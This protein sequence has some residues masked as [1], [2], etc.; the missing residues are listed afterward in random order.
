MIR[1]Y[2]SA[3][4]S[5][6][7]RIWLE[8]NIETHDF[9]PE[10]YWT[11]NYEPVKDMLPQAEIYVYEA[12]GSGQAEGFIGLTGSYIAGLFV[13]AGAQSK[14]IGTKLLEHAMQRRESLTLSVYRKNTRAI[15]FY[16]RHGFVI[17]SESIDSDT[18]EDEYTMV[19]NRQ[20]E[21][22]D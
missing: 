17:R 12:D 10:E 18:G 3:D 13:S 19:W 11:D 2:A 8:T 20:K 6:I 15:D 9:I 14:G 16:R 21:L 7:M 22:E 4:T 1:R 5:H